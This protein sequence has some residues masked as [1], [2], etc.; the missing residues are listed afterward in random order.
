MS[1]LGEGTLTLVGGSVTWVYLLKEF[2]WKME[3]CRFL[4]G[5]ILAVLLSR[6]K[7]SLGGGGI[8]EKKPR[9]GH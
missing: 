8:S 6:G 7:A 1:Q 9:E 3:H 4:A 2:S 5:L